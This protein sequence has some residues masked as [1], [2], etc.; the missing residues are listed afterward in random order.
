[1]S[2]RKDIWR[3]AVIEAPLAEIWARGS[4]ADLPI[5]W[6]PEEPA[7]RYLADP[8]GL[9][10][11]GL[12]FVF[13]EAYDHRD[14]RG[15]IHALVFDSALR[16]IERNT[17]LV[18]PWHLSYPYVFTAD[19]ET[20]LLPEAAQSG[21]LTLYRATAFPYCWERAWRIDVDSSAVD[22]TPVWFEDMWWLFYAAGPRVRGRSAEL[23][24]AYAERLAGPWRPHPA[25][26][27]RQ[28]LRGS[29]PGGTAIV[30]GGRLVLPVQDCSATYGGA[31]R[32]LLFEHLDRE[33]AISSLGPPLL[34]PPEAAPYC[35]G[36]HTLSAAGGVTLA[37]VKTSVITMCGL[38][39]DTKRLARRLIGRGTTPS[40]ERLA[41]RA[42]VFF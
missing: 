42:A 1:M 7:L 24:C 28:G 20:W 39:L 6:F 38:A 13:V 14:R 40:G 21:R 31:L 19:G 33:R 5:T 23:H 11:D 25:N 35:D 2:L 10:I 15:A 34:P 12:L 41:D 36:I 18:E 22:A 8:F 32:P 29:R 26:P 16:L 9:W 27:I 4:I 30:G 17:V 37:D 3:P